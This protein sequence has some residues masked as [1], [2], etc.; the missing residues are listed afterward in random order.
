MLEPGSGLGLASEALDEPGILG[1]AAVQQLQRDL[2]PELLVLGQED[3]GH[4]ARA[5]PGKDPVAT[6]YDCAL[7]QFRH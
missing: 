6:V 2:A 1:E 7:I 4:P 5:E 3:V